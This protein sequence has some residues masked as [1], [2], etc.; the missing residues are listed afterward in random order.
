MGFSI[1]VGFHK[2]E[3]HC[4]IVQFKAKK[5]GDSIILGSTILS[6]DT[7][8]LLF[9]KGEYLEKGTDFDQTG[10]ISALI[11]ALSFFNSASRLAL[12]RS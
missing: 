3:R 11:S 7:R 5:E 6:P 8:T 12:I 1:P 2:E 10:E 9:E 4:Y